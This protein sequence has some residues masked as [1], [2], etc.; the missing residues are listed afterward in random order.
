[1]ISCGAVVTDEISPEVV[2]DT[3]VEALVV[4]AVHEIHIKYRKVVFLEEIHDLL[5]VSRA[6]LQENAGYAIGI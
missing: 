1:M 2:T 5:I 4:F 3:E 6:T